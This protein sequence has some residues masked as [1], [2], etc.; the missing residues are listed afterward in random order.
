[1]KARYLLRLEKHSG[2]AAGDALSLSN[3]AGKVE[4]ASW[5]TRQ[6]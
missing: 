4:G 1:M 6:A 5:L 3:C 2:A